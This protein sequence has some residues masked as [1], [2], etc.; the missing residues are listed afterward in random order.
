MY[1]TDDIVYRVDNRYLGPAGR[2]LPFGPR[3]TTVAVGAAIFLALLVVLR[4]VLHIEFSYRV[5]LVLAVTT[6]WITGR[7][8]ARVTPENPLMSILRAG[9]NDLLAPRTRKTE[10]PVA[11]RYTRRLQP[12]KELV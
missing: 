6:A 12:P 8:M 3:V 4:V 7:V 11:Q 10:L 2:T 9:R 5:F 1:E